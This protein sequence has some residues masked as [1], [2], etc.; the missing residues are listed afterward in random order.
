MT[1]NVIAN[2]GKMVFANNIILILLLREGKKAQSG[3]KKNLVALPV[4]ILYKQGEGVI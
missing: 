3:G 2:H 1:F 4:G